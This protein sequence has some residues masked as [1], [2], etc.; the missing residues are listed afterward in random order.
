M[1]NNY[2][3]DKA[4][5]RRE[6]D[7][8]LDY[9]RVFYRNYQVAPV[10]FVKNRDNRPYLKFHVDNSTY[11]GI[12]DSGANCCVLGANSHLQF[13]ELGYKIKQISSKTA[14]TVDG[15]S[16]K[17][18]GTLDLPVTLD[19]ITKTISFLIIPSF[20]PNIILGFDFWLK[21]DLAKDLF[22]NIKY[23]N[24]KDFN[25]GSVTSAANLS[26]SETEQLNEVIG[27]FED[28]SY[29]KNGLGLTHLTEHKIVTTGEPIKQRYYPLSPAKQKEI[30]D[31][32]ESMLKENIIQPSKSPWS[33]PVLTVPKKDGGIRLCLDSRK[34]NSVT[35]KDSYPLPYTSAILDNLRNAKY[36][37]AID[38]S[39][40]FLQIKLDLS[41]REKTA[42]CIP[43]KGLFEFVRMPFGLSNAP[44]ELQRL[45]DKLFGPE[46]DKN[47]FAYLDDLICISSNFLE[48]L[49]L[50]RKV[51]KALKAAGLTVNLKKC[52]FCKER[53]LYLGYVVDSQGLH[54]DPS[55][56]E[57]IKNFPQPKTVKQLRSFLGL[58]SYYRRFISKFADIAAPLTK[59]TGGSKKIKTDLNWNEE[60][61]K[62]FNT[63][64]HCLITSPVLQCPDFSKAF[65]LHCDASSVGIG[66]VLSQEDDNGEQHPVAFYSRSLNNCER[67]YSTTEREL[68]AILDSIEHFR[69]YIEG[70]KFTVITD[71]ASLK[72][73]LSLNNP[74]GRLARWAARISQFT[75]DIIHKKG[76]L[77]VVPDTLSRFDVALFVAPH[78]DI[79][80]PW[81]KKMFI[82]CQK[83]P[84]KYKNFRVEN[85][86]LYRFCKSK[87]SLNNSLEW[88][89]VIPK[90]HVLDTI[91]SNHDNLNSC[92]L[93]IHKT[94]NKIKLHY[95]WK[96][97]FFDVQ[98]YV[99]NCDICKAYKH[100]N[101]KPLGTMIN[102]KKVDKPM[103]MLSMDLI[104]ILPKSYSGH[105]Y[106]LSVVDV[107]TKYCWLFPLVNATTRSITRQLEKEIFLK[108]GCPKIIIC[109]NGTQFTSKNFVDFLKSF[110]IN[111]IFYNTLYTP[112]NNPVE[113]YNKTVETCISCFVQEDHRT[114]SKFLSHIQLA[115][116]SSVNLATEFTP[117]FLMFGRE[118]IIDASLHRFSNSLNDLSEVDIV[119]RSNFAFSLSSLE[120]IFEKVTTSLL[121]AYKR[122]SI[123][124][125]RDRKV[126]SY[127]IGDIVWRK[128][129]VL[130]S[131]AHYFSAKLAPKF[132]KCKIIDKISNNVYVLK[133]LDKGSSGRYH[134]KDILKI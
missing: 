125:N 132:V 19:N 20:E 28:I 43:G 118:V 103:V 47:T 75:F 21:F 37:T 89:I 36:I 123:Y 16:Q 49:E 33:S 17:I 77:H 92:H 110:N 71:H 127:S 78:D 4:T 42:F 59:L 74:S 61:E 124:Y 87:Y 68:L 111:K 73:L 122:N 52:E 31:E 120:A 129:F 56:L 117:N 94:L 90:E 70:M 108:F 113:R 12:L 88:K 85:D 63:L 114:W 119:D 93:G 48:H 30:H 62:A 39:K 5:C 82:N 50:L 18:I 131:A 22:K 46:F 104:G 66:S 84:C 115:L 45:V 133:D 95:Y 116:N 35:V 54:T 29:E 53:L 76:S 57:T 13:L 34:L 38:L 91:R 55:K 14:H 112:Q 65:F 1:E 6:F 96:G 51:H 100:S 67:N 79:V 7:E 81:Y 40:A 2:V 105:R 97:M 8:W 44:A 9:L 26:P 83:T 86:T 32:V 69:P 15:T 109:D 102:P 130:S 23:C 11:T 98:K 3:P 64:K 60:A 128:N 25:V 80:D 121:K 27:L 41:S 134:V 72:W 106:I 24:D 99:N 107:F 101:S 10:L 58:C 126:T